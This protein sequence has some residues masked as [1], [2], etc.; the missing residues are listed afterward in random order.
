MLPKRGGEHN[1]RHS[2]RAVVLSGSTFGDDWIQS[3]RSIFSR[4]SS[5]PSV[6]P[7]SK[8]LVLMTLSKGGTLL[9]IPPG[10]Y[11]C[12]KQKYGGASNGTLTPQ[13]DSVE[14]GHALLW[15][16]LAPAPSR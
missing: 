9:S 2:H 4:I 12:A 3:F 10:F 16:T 5:P 13:S 8:A 14:T 11:D 7:E 6:V 15:F 1:Y